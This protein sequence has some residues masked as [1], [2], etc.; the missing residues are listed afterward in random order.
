MKT[1]LAAPVLALVALHVPQDAQATVDLLPHRAA[2]RLSLMDSDGRGGMTDVRG[3]LVME[4]QETCEGWLNQQQLAFVAD[5][6]E[7][8]RFSY[9]V[10]FSSW[11]AHDH[12]AMRFVVRSYDD[13]MPGEDFRGQAHLDVSGGGGK[14][15]YADPEGLV[16]DLPPDTVFPTEHMRR[17]IENA[18]AGE[19]VFSSKVFDGSGPEALN[20]IAA[21]IGRA[22]ASAK[23]IAETH[24]ERVWPVSLA[25]Y[26]PDAQDDLPQ[27]EVSFDMTERGVLSN[28]KLDYGDF[29]LKGDLERIDVLEEP[30]N[31]P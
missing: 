9:D 1:L 6:A 4:W 17:L 22:E 12:T 28:L 27:F 25:Y 18:K 24:G 23:H 5:L 19:F 26:A 2:Y 10:R 14:A 15:A 31:C 7:G 8:L 13:G 3:G 30:Q 16:I 20:T 11:E 29:I 21:V